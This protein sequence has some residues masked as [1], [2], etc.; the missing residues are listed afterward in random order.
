MASSILEASKAWS[1]LCQTEQSWG[2]NIVIESLPK[3][4]KDFFCDLTGNGAFEGFWMVR[5]MP[6]GTEENSHINCIKFLQEKDKDQK[7]QILRGWKI[8]YTKDQTCCLIYHSILLNT[9]T[10][11]KIDITPMPNVS[12]NWKANAF[13]MDFA[14]FAACRE[15][16]ENHLEYNAMKNFNNKPNYLVSFPD[17]KAKS[18]TVRKFEGICRFVD[19]D[20]KPPSYQL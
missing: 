4:E 5:Y 9:E 13:I 3:L 12:E 11:Q 14:D 1:F 7:Y 8:S 10:E 15:V 16:K 6:V 17:K 19:I 2:K 20:N 18:L